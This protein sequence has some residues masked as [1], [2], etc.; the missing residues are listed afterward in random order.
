MAL[1]SSRK[2]DFRPH[3]RVIRWV[4]AL[5]HFALDPRVRARRGQRFPGQNSINAQAAIF[6]KRKHSVIPPAEDPWLRMMQAQRIRQAYGAERAKGGAFAIR[7]HDSAP[8]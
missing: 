8:P 6:R 3:G 4:P 7:T 5:A 1:D 2:C